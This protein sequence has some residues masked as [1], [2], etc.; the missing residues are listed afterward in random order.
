MS[1]VQCSMSHVP[2]EGKGKHRS[3]EQMR[4][5]ETHSINTDMQRAIPSRANIRC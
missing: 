3:S 1:E 2:R 5:R 4:G